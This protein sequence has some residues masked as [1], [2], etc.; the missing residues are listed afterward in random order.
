[1]VVFNQGQ[2]G[3]YDTAIAS[4]SPNAPMKAHFLKTAILKL[5]KN[6]RDDALR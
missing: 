2:I 1:M 6:T 3:E 4:I 5:D